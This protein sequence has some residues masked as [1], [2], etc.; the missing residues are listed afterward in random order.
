MGPN[1]KY[2]VL[3]KNSHNTVKECAWCALCCVVW[4]VLLGGCV[5]VVWGV[6]VGVGGPHT[7]GDILVRYP[8]TGCHTSH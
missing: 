4:S 8:G 1:I 3:L 5:G 2:V 7:V 6:L